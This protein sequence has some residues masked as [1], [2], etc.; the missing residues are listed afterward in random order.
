MQ[1]KNYPPPVGKFLF[2]IRFADGL[3]RSRGGSAPFFSP[4]VVH[5]KGRSVHFSDQDRESVVSKRNLAHE[6]IV[7]RSGFA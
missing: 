7:N 6:G 5:A 4:P 2:P 1:L 3:E